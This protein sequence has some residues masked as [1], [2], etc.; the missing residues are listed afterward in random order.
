MGP[1]RFCSNPTM[2]R[3]R[4]QVSYGLY[5]SAEV[6]RYPEARRVCRLSREFV[7]SHDLM[8]D[9]RCG[10]DK[11]GVGVLRCG[12]CAS[13]GSTSWPRSQSPNRAWLG[14]RDLP[15][16]RGQGCLR[17][18]T[19]KGRLWGR[20]RAA[21]M[22]TGR[23]V[24]RRPERAEGAAGGRLRT[25]EDG[26]GGLRGGSCASGEGGGRREQQDSHDDH[27]DT[28]DEDDVRALAGNALG[29]C[30]EFLRRRGDS[31]RVSLAGTEWGLA[32]RARRAEGVD[33]ARWV[34]EGAVRVPGRRC[35]TP[36]SQK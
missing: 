29:H 6:T 34:A 7:S 33:Q 1:S 25:L 16:R 36:R 19:G 5:R 12:W 26:F 28:A 35:P 18:S 9:P 13:S 3:Y 8:N 14:G 30:V 24:H 10:M 11:I 17:T 4:S 31:Q 23:A 22:R 27:Q 15:C 21:G 20:R 2:R 32:S